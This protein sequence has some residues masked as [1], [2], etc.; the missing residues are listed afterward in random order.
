MTITDNM[1]EAKENHD[2]ADDD[3]YEHCTPADLPDPTIS[4]LQ[5]IYHMMQECSSMSLAKAV[6]SVVCVYR[7]V[8]YSNTNMWIS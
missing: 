2:S 5:K 1:E 6:L 4:N 8:I 7:S 3:I